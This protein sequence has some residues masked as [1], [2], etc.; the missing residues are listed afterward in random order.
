M[1]SSA[2]AKGASLPSFKSFHQTH[3]SWWPFPNL[4]DAYTCPGCFCLALSTWLALHVYDI[5]VTPPL[6]TRQQG[7]GSARAGV[8]AG[9]QQVDHPSFPCHAPRDPRWPLVSR[10]PLCP[11]LP[12][13]F[14]GQ[15]GFIP[16]CQSAW[17][18]R[19]GCLE[20][21]GWL[22]GDL[23]RTLLKGRLGLHNRFSQGDSGVWGNQDGLLAG[24][25]PRLPVSNLS[26]TLYT[27]V[28]LLAFCFQP[29]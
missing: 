20:A 25:P 24:W 21:G 19:A 14:P 17:K 26:P 7:G 15:K 12:P 5:T 13:Q 16:S 22:Q 27:D 6:N 9:I 3:F 1:L 8:M 28:S 23:G 2:P 4:S 11:A 29:C 18:K 10:K